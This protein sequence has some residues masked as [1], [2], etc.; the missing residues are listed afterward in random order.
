MRYSETR[1][2][3]VTKDWDISDAHS[4]IHAHFVVNGHDTLKDGVP[5]ILY[6]IQNKLLFLALSRLDAA[7]L[8]ASGLSTAFSKIFHVLLASQVTCQ[9]KIVSTAFFSVTALGRKLNT[10]KFHRWRCYC[11]GCILRYR[12]CQPFSDIF[13]SFSGCYRTSECS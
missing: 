8:Q 11:G 6:V 10:V 9:M 7:T 12:I 4:D 5:V 3:F 1:R 13:F 2:T